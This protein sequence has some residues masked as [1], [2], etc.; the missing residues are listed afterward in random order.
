MFAE[1]VVKE[2]LPEDNGFI[3]GVVPRLCIANLYLS[4]AFIV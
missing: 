3:G 2:T 4:K 1:S